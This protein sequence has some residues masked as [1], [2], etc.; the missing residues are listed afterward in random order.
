MVRIAR[1]VWA[2]FEFNL[3]RARS[4]ALS[5]HYLELVVE[6]GEDA[7]KEYID[8]VIGQTLGWFGF[9]LDNMISRV[10]AAVEA[11][12]QAELAE[13]V[14]AHEDEMKK[15]VAELSEMEKA[16]GIPDDLKRIL[17]PFLTFRFLSEQTL[18]ESAVV[19]AVAA[20]EAYLKDII[21]AEA[22]RRPSVLKAF[23]R[24]RDAID[25]RVIGQYGGKLRLAQGEE[26]ARSLDAFR[27]NSVR[28]YFKRIF[29]VANIFG[30][31][32]LEREMNQLIQRRHLIVH[33]GGIVDH[34]FRRNTGSRQRLN[35]R[36]DLPYT[37]VLRYVESVREFGERVRRA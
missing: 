30:T 26:L 4:L 14:K 6:R 17:E 22:R 19:V 34:E 25:L 23:P 37:A 12:L 10:K 11:P 21:S 7:V 1:Q 8:T 3:G 15:R 33:R 18:A 35:E 32:R 20:Y 2:T 29:G 36:L 9:S 24:V 16:G 13:Y 31:S 28:S 27:T 5:Q